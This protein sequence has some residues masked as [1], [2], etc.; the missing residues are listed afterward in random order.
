MNRKL[1][2]PSLL[3]SHR[4][5]MAILTTHNLS[6]STPDGRL[7]FQDLDLSLD[8]ERTGLIGRNGSGKTTL[9]KMLAGE[10]EPAGGTL[11]R[12]GVVRL[13]RQ[14]IGGHPDADIS[15]AFGVA[16]ELEQL[17]DFLAGRMVPDDVSR[18]DWTL[19]D[20]VKVS[21]ERAGLDDIELGRRLAML[22]GGQRMRVALA[23]LTFDE[24]D[25]I[26]LDEPTNNLDRQGRRFVADLIERFQGGMLV[27]SHDRD[28][29]RRMDRIVELSSTGI[30]IYGG[31]W[32]AYAEIRAA[33]REA[34]ER[35]VAVAERELKS[36]RRRIQADRERKARRDAAGRKAGK[37]GGDSK[38]VIGKRANNAENTLGRANRLAETEQSR[39]SDRL[40]VARKK[41]ERDK[42]L[43]AA[44]PS[45]GLPAGR[46]VL[47]CERVSAGYDAGH[48]VIRDLGL[49]VVGP[50][51]IVI[52]G[53]NGSGKTTLLKLIS[54]AL[55]PRAGTVHVIPRVMMLDQEA[56]I[57]DRRTTI[58]ENFRRLNPDDPEQK[59]RA[60]LA[61][62][63]FRADAALRPVSDLS[64][65]EIIRAGL[66]CVL[67][68]RNTPQLLM[69][70][71]PTNHLDLQ[72]V[73]AVEQ[74]LNGYDGALLIISHDTDFLAN[75][76]IEREIVLGA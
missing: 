62:F 8:R 56:A 59:C 34:A 30:R 40:T 75:L 2:S 5:P 43:A 73:E 3:F 21:L 66:A 41:I 74:G 64:G 70:D 16:D 61:R 7:L 38:L 35:G 20:R 52:G 28:L 60:A 69:L 1:I 46:T 10:A 45:T 6:G 39:A 33:E 58:L 50:E 37:S 48:P 17:A 23:A 22:S 57:L 29:L 71:E 14:D 53:P 25:L 26:L 11:Q 63:L 49:S 15:T 36:V 55:K 72:S 4:Y 18:V 76:G 68:G 47:S 31:N 44:L 12:N 32:D 13:L 9:L 65:G 19:D 27:V 51:R 24:P 42:S 67:G 54:G